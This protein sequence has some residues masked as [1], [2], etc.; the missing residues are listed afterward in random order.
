[1]KRLILKDMYSWSVFSE[2]RQ[3]D[4]NAHLWVRDEGNIVISLS[5]RFIEKDR[6]STI[7]MVRTKRID[8]ASS[9]KAT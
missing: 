2:V 8:N 6:V 1:M 4:F 9:I 5:E 7:L 3:I